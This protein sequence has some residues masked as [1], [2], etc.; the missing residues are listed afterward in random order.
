MRRPKAEVLGST[1]WRLEHEI[2]LFKYLKTQD[3]GSQTGT[4]VKQAVPSLASFHAPVLNSKIRTIRKKIQDFGHSYDPQVDSKPMDL[5]STCSLACSAEDGP[6]DDTRPPTTPQVPRTLPGTPQSLPP[7]APGMPDVRRLSGL[8]AGS[9]KRVKIE[10]PSKSELVDSMVYTKPVVKSAPIQ[11]TL[12]LH[13]LMRFKDD[14]TGLHHVQIILRILTD[15]HMQFDVSADG[16]NFVY[17]LKPKTVSAVDFI[18]PEHSSIS[19]PPT[20]AIVQYFHNDTGMEEFFY[21]VALPEAVD[22]NCIS[23][24]SVYRAVETTD[25]SGYKVTIMQAVAKVLV[26]MVSGQRSGNRESDW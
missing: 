11:S 26:Y 20:T 6:D 5:S 17:N 23:N 24:R 21:T 19:H 25:T 18:D 8:V 3:D 14:K 22:S 13:E 7:G 4:Q 2:A 12:R 9:V 10:S 1:D 16:K 15:H